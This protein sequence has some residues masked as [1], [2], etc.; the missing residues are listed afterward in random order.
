MS[1]PAAPSAVPDD[2]ILLHIGPHKTGTTAIQWILAA[3][4]EDM[5]A[6][7][8]TYPAGVAHHR[9]ARALRR[10]PA[11]WV[12]DTEVLPE[13][14]VWERFAAA[15][16]G[17]AGRVVISSE[18]FAQ[19][20]AEARARIVEDLGR[21][22][23]HV[24]IAARNPGSIALST[25]QQVLRDGKAAP[26]PVWL[27]KRFRRDAPARA[28]EGFWSWADAATLAEEWTGLLGADRVHVV[29]IDEKDRS[30]LPGTVERLLD[31][32]AGLLSSRKPTQSNRGLSAVEAELVQ[33]VVGLTRP[34][35]TWAQ[36]SLL[37]RSGVVQRLLSERTPG[38]G[39][40]RSALPRWAAEQAAT[41]AESTITRLTGLGVEISGNLDHLRRVPAAGDPEP[42][43]SLPIDV[44]AEAVAGAMLAA[45]RGLEQA[46]RAGRRAGRGAGQPRRR[47]GHAVEDIPTRELVRVVG[48]RVRRRVLPGR[49]G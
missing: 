7:G 33:R 34:H 3:A 40:P 13:P 30:H 44:A 22:R 42:V 17:T 36:F 48:A 29:V 39:E 28:T 11:G 24:L 16:T 20:D 18:F 15:V 27:D 32:P 23:L 4:R 2:A 9:E 43:T 41:E 49:R 38:E 21:D 37:V 26:L 14:E 31:L 12:D 8:V 1:E 25:W 19:S 35:L 47:P 5:A 45:V 10:H 46:E 6:H